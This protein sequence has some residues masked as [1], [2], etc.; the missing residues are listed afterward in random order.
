MTSKTTLTVAH[1]FDEVFFA[2]CAEAV[3]DCLCC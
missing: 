3:G 1:G 2:W